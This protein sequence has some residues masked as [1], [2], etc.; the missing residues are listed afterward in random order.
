MS[1]SL[2][3]TAF[4]IEANRDH[5]LAVSA[6]HCFEEIRKRLY[7]APQHHSSAL[8]EF[9][10][11]L[12][13]MDLSQVK[14]LYLG[15]DKEPVACD[16]ELGVW[17][18]GTDYAL[19][20]VNAPNCTPSLFNRFLCLG[21]QIP[22]VNECV[23]MIGFGEM[24]V[25]PH[26][27]NA[28]AGIIQRRLILRVGHVENIHP[29][30]YY[31]LKA[32]C[33]ETSIAIFGGMSGGIVARW[34]AQDTPIRPFGFISHAPEPQPTHDRSVSGHSFGAILNLERT[35]IAEGKQR[36]SVQLNNIGVGRKQS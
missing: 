11:P 28:K 20:K 27:E 2:I 23:A 29:S 15:D 34:G 9:L 25:T 26:V 33:I 14:G 3:G 13:E 12:P 8:P 21:D 31:M 17:D 4:L 5:A 16:I 19:L 7:P 1:V 30:G 32:P 18:R 6:A 35:I 22:Q 24:K 36:I 10:P